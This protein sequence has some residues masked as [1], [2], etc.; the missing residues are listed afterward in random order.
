[1]KQQIQNVCLNLALC[2][3]LSTSQLFISL[4]KQAEEKLIR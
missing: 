4:R 3:A 2:L 1:M